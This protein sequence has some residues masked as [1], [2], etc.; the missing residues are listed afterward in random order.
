[1][2]LRSVRC[3]T[4]PPGL[5]AVALAQCLA[6]GNAFAASDA[7]RIAELERK[8][9]LMSQ[10]LQ[11]ME[12]AVAHAPVAPAQAPSDALAGKVSELEQQVAAMSNAPDRDRGLVV[13]G[14]A[15]VGLSAAG[16]GHAVGA[17][18]G[19]LD[20]YLTPQFGDRVKSLF[21]LNFEVSKDGV[22]GVDLERIQLG[23]TVSDALTVWAGRF[24]TPFG[25]WNTAFHHGAQ[26]QTSIARPAFLEFEDSGGIL[27]AHTVGLWANGSFKTDGGRL[28]YD[29]YAGNA[30]TI[31]LSDPSVPGTGTLDPGLAGADARK[32]S[33]GANLNFAFKGAAE[34][35]HVGVHTLS[36][37]VSDTATVVTS[38]HVTMFGGWLAYL[39]DDWEVMAEEYSFRNR[40]VDGGGMR[41]SSNAAYAQVGRQFGKWTP[42]GRYEITSLDQNDAYFAQQIGGQS[43]KRLMVGLRYD[44]NPSAAL[45]LEA[46]RTRHTDRNIDSYSEL[47][48]QLAI[49]F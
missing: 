41:H 48:S 1:M 3:P 31:K 36:S 37:T 27:P 30:P 12:A 22:L 32:A 20:F 47:R 29:L 34:G 17:K 44:I 33:I 35:L 6:I 13:H 46:T 23:Y 49:R 21:E 39:E 38:T 24:H 28:G 42:Y 26:L 10:R 16:E 45:K 18:A 43:Y 8:L 2:R 25:Y 11:Q 7:E 40:Q 14:F 5:L 15:D 9:E 19:S 4:R